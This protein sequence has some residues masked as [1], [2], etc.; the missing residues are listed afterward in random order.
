MFRR[1]RLLAIAVLWILSVVVPNAPSPL[2]AHGEAGD[3]PAEAALAPAPPPRAHKPSPLVD[4]NP[5]NQLR[6]RAESGD[7]ESQYQLGVRY[8]TGVLVPR[9]PAEAAKWYRRAA[10]QGHIVA[11]T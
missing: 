3:A 5:V 10:D 1:N 2:T 7:P 11:E 9:D 6:R 4:P 8:Q